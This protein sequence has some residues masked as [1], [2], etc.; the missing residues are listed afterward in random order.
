MAGSS[1][2]ELFGVRDGFLRY[3]RDGLGWAAP[4]VV[5]PHRADATARGLPLSDEEALGLVRRR[6][7]DLRQELGDLYHF[8]VGSEGGLHS[9]EVEGQ[10]HYFVRSWTVVVGFGE[11]A[12]GASGSLELPPRLIRGLDQMQVPFAVPGTRRRGGM[13]SSLTG[14][15]ETRRQAVATACLHALS[16]MFYGVLEARPAAG[17]VPRPRRG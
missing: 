13:I 12:W 11:E 15:L 4:V 3:F 6:V 17:F 5:A 9:L 10:L 1:P 14:G 2:E 16:T 8:C 7:A